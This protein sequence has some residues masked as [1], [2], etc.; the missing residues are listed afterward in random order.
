MEHVF[1]KHNAIALG[2]VFYNLVLPSRDEADRLPLAIRRAIRTES[3]HFPTH[4]LEFTCT[5]NAA[6]SWP[7]TMSGVQRCGWCSR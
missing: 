7:S 1:H 3:V 5:W 4:A 6:M 2:A